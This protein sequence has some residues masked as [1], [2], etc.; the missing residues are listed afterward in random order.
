MCI[1]G[2]MLQSSQKRTC[3]LLWVRP[4]V[5]W[6]L[7]MR[8]GTSL[9]QDLSR[10]T[11]GN[12]MLSWDEAAFECAEAL[13]FFTTSPWAREV[14]IM[15]CHTYRF[16]LT[17][18]LDTGQET[19]CDGEQCFPDRRRLSLPRSVDKPY[20]IMFQWQGLRHDMAGNC[21]L[22]R[23]EMSSWQETQTGHRKEL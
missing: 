20:S 15:Y 17:E 5:C 18:I 3:S 11:I 19:Q 22:T 2:P 4:V 12:C 6:C 23:L 14:R 9:W 16:L 7:L 21:I 10:D 13:T 8:T 1:A